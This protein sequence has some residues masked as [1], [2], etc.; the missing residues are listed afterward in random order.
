[1]NWP[2]TCNRRLSPQPLADDDPLS[3]VQG[4]GSIS[5][6]MGTGTAAVINNGFVLSNLRSAQPTPNSSQPST[7]VNFNLAFSKSAELKLWRTGSIVDT[8][9]ASNWLTGNRS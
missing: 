9:P 6:L 1:M 2:E 8:Y 7:A 3:Q 4:E 5:L